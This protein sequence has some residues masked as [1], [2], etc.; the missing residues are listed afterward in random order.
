MRSVDIEADKHLQGLVSKIESLS[1][2][3]LV[4][5]IEFLEH[6]LLPNDQLPTLERQTVLLK[7]ILEALEDREHHGLQVD[8]R[9]WEVELPSPDEFL[10][11]LGKAHLEEHAQQPSVHAPFAFALDLADVLLPVVHYHVLLLRLLPKTQ[12]GEASSNEVL[13]KTLRDDLEDLARKRVA[14]VKRNLWRDLEAVGEQ[15]RLLE[16]QL[17]LVQVQ[18]LDQLAL[19]R[20]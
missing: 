14:T 2:A 19:S 3:E 10:G 17:I 4:D 20:V 11:T 12:Y 1:L 8:G 9:S 7:G 18:R 13:R 5:Q 16:L 6:L 15:R